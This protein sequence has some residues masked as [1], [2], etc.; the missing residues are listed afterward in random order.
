M[1][2]VYPQN[3]SKTPH[4]L[5]ASIPYKTLIKALKQVCEG[6]NIPA[7]IEESK[8][9][10]E[11]SWSSIPC[12]TITHPK[13]KKKYHSLVIELKD[14]YGEHYCYVHM[15][16]RSRNQR[17]INMGKSYTYI[18]SHGEIAQH[19]PGFL[20]R[21]F[22]SEGE[23][24]IK[25]EEL[26]YD[27]LYKAIATALGL[28]EDWILNPPRRSPEPRPAPV[29]NAESHTTAQKKEASKAAPVQETHSQPAP[30]KEPSN[31]EP[32]HKLEK[33]IG[34][35]TMGGI[36]YK[37]ISA[38]T[39]I[40][41]EATMTF[42]TASDKQASVE[43]NVLQG[44]SEKACDNVSLGKYTLGGI[45]PAP[46]GVP[47]IEVTFRVNK[48]GE[49][50]VSATDKGTGK[51]LDVF[52][53][54]VLSAHQEPAEQEP[55]EPQQQKEAPP[56]AEF[57]FEVSQSDDELFKWMDSNICLL[58]PEGSTIDIIA[59]H[60]YVPTS[61]TVVLSAA[62]DEGCSFDIQVI[63]RNEAAAHTLGKITLSNIP[64]SSNGNLQ[65]ELF[66][67]VQSKGQ[68]SV[69]AKLLPSGKYLPIA[70]SCNQ[71]ATAEK[72]APQQSA[73]AEKSTVE[74]LQ[75]L[76]DLLDRGVLTQEEFEHLKKKILYS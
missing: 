9:S 67:W 74:Q 4:E 37:L 65:I 12:I 27:V 14:A 7:D 62:V 61:K 3:Q 16:G 46:R 28:A 56:S 40:P 11:G 32:R 1:I 51:D 13:Q 44:E 49:L 33:S 57:Q 20:G 60:T 34:L 25:D 70:F 58:T 52:V 68:V 5:R 59:K 39:Y 54:N 30:E 26:Y 19:T 71:P 17:D 69:T 75:D 42:S 36:F 43:I 15:G 41:A 63:T 53:D 47:E 72:A 64:Y 29:P 22:S 66:L 2:T 76:V 73:P 8:Y 6:K 48:Y 31:S 50:D 21:L 38:G 18:N 55:P 35:E 10:I 45:A 24:G 23:A